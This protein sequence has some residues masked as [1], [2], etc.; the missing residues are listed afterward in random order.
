MLQNPSGH[1]PQRRTR[2]WIPLIVCALLG[3]LPSFAA[4]RVQVLNLSPRTTGSGGE[5][6]IDLGGQATVPNLAY[7]RHS[8]FITLANGSFD[9]TVR[10]ERGAV[11]TM[12][13]VNLADGRDHLIAAIGDGRE[14][15]FAVYSNT[16]HAQ[17]VPNGRFT[18]QSAYLATNGSFADP[19]SRQ[20][21]ALACDEELPTLPE[22]SNR[23]PRDDRFGS[24]GVGNLGYG[25]SLAAD[26]CI[27]LAFVVQHTIDGRLETHSTEIRAAAGER[28]RL[29]AVGDGVLQ[30]IEMLVIRYGIEATRA[31][32]PPDPRMEGLWYDPDRPGEGF[33]MLFDHSVSPPRPQLLFYGYDASNRSS[34]G[35]GIQGIG[36][37]TLLETF[38]GG[39]PSGQFPTAANPNPAVSLY[40]HSCTEAS[41]ETVTNNEVIRHTPSDLARS[42][43]L[44]KLLPLTDCGIGAQP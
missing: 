8:E 43:H 23:N 21:L 30:P 41:L 3:N 31:F 19:L 15:G 24:D 37:Y 5:L 32:I 14:R 26:S 39:S 17:T 38:R 25:R 2:G 44:V 29:F 27:R 6:T 28:I 36:P 4:V 40:F 16:Q 12:R 7:K 35:A 13:R 20:Y 42:R 10:D 9:V 1:V 11:L 34:W 33:A 22:L 18:V